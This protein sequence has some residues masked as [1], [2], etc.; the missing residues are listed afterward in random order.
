MDMENPYGIFI[1]NFHMDTDHMDI[2]ITTFSHEIQKTGGGGGGGLGR[3]AFHTYSGKV[4]DK[5][6][7]RL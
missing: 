6:L 5:A 4:F 1:W 7:G 3:F 2:W